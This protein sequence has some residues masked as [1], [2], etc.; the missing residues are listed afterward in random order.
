MVKKSFNPF[1]MWGAWVGLVLGLVVGILGALTVLS[2]EI[3]GFMRCDGINFFTSLPMCSGVVSGDI[4]MFLAQLIYPI[5]GLLIG[6]G[7]HSLIRVV[8]K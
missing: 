3:E 2:Y 4:L 7:I 1:K 5:I 8:R 6:W